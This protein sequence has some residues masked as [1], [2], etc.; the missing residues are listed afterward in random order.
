MF[1]GQG[2]SIPH[3]KG[4]KMSVFFDETYY[5]KAKLAQ[6]HSI[7]EKDSNGNAYTLTTLQKAIADAG[8]TPETHY[9]QFGSTEKLNPAPYFNEA[10]YLIAKTNQVNSIAQDGRSNWTVDEVKAAIDGIGMTP[11]EHYEV[12]G[13]HETDAKGNLINPSNGFDSN[14]YVAAKLAELVKTE[15]EQWAGKTAADVVAAIA[16]AGMSPVTHYEMHGVT[17]ANAFG[18]ALVQT[19]PV[20]L[21]VENDPARATVTGGLCLP[22]TTRPRP[23][24]PP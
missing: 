2:L 12:F 23:R 5:L 9:Q 22:T 1:W 13:G 16:E 14:A 7:G 15:P 4:G 6:L 8:L 17:E 19:V 11:A 24:R 10:Q 21:R 3:G 18:V 20:T